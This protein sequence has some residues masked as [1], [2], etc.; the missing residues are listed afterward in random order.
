MPPGTLMIDRTLPARV[1]PRRLAALPLSEAV[2][3]ISLPAGDHRIP[4]TDD[5]PD[6]SFFSFPSEFDYGHRTSIVTTRDFRDPR[7][8]LSCRPEKF[9]DG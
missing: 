8:R 7:M 2:N 9:S 1:T 4:C 3:Q 5:Q 6:E